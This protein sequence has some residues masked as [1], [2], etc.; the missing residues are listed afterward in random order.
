MNRVV[1]LAAVALVAA[2]GLVACGGGSGSSDDD[3]IRSVADRALTGNDPASCDELLTAHFVQTFYG[4]SVEQCRKNAEETSTNP[5]SVDVTN[6]S[7]NGE[8]ASADIK[9]V[10]GPSDGQVLS[11]IFVKQGSQW[12][13]DSVS[14]SSGSDTTTPGSSTGATTGTTPSSTGD[15]VVDLFFATIRS[16]LKKQGQSDQAADCIVNK[17]HTVITPKDLDE[18]KAGKKPADL[19]AK[20]RQVG[21][22]CGHQALSP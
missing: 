20:V 1:P 17:L 16:Q 9:L 8:K 10:G 18:L 15:P 22:E 11:A 3:Q 5:D 7:V 19:S 6:I 2:L 4:G 14:T 12:K 13:F 21:T